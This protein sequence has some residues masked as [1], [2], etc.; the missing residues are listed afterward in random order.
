MVQQQLQQALAPMLQ[1]ESQQ[2]QQSEREV[3]QTVEAMAFDPKYPYF[4]E[5]REDMADIMEISTRRGVAMTLDE[6][7]SRAT[8]MNPDVYGQ[9]ERQGNMT[10]ANQQNLQAQRAKVA[11]SSVTGSPASGGMQQHVGDG[12]LR[13]AIEAAFGGQRL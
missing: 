13:G 9:L 7:Y 8:R 6:A 5:V 4:E 10:N 12:S 2:R 11:A 3:N 1:R